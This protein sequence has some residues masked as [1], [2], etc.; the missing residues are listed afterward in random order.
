MGT[1]SAPRW[2]RE[3]LYFFFFP[4][5]IAIFSFP[6]NSYPTLV[7]VDFFSSFFFVY[8]CVILSCWLAA[9]HV[10][11]VKMSLYFRPEYTTEREREEIHIHDAVI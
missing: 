3:L 5:C 7:H 2:R 1:L 6:F 11:G 9:C 10:V 8:R 4:P